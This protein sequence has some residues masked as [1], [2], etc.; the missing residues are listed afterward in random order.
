MTAL[1]SRGRAYPVGLGAATYAAVRAASTV[2]WPGSSFT[3]ANGL[4]TATASTLTMTLPGATVATAWADMPRLRVD[5]GAGAAQGSFQMWARLAAVSGLDANTFLPF[6][7]RDA[8]GNL[9]VL[10]QT[11]GVGVVTVYDGSGLIANAGAIVG[12]TGTE[13]FRVT[14]SNWMLTV[15]YSSDVAAGR[16]TPISRE[17]ARPAVPA[18]VWT[19]SQIAFNLYQGVGAAGTVSAQWAD[20]RSITF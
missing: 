5:A 7:L 9:L 20:V 13:G 16:W 18:S 4:G 3:A 14:L 6:A 19:Y 15:E 2:T 10:V 12:F 17:V 1:A 11:S 8:S